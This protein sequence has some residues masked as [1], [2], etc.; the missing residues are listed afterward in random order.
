VLD[1]GVNYTLGM[2]LKGSTVS[3]TLN[4]QVVLGYAYNASTVDGRFGLMAVTG[5][6]QFDNVTVKTTD[7]AVA[8]SMEHMLAADSPNVSASV[9]TITTGDL[10]PII[11]E[12][13]RRLSLTLDAAQIAA[14]HTVTFQVTDLPWLEIGDYRDGTIWIDADAAGYGWFVDRTPGDDREFASQDGTLLA[15]SGLAA[16][17][18]DLLT[19]V[20]HELGHVVGLER[21][22][23]GVM[24]ASLTAGTRLAPAVDP[25]PGHGALVPVIDWQG[26]AFG[27]GIQGSAFGTGIQGTPLP[28]SESAGWMTDFA[29]HL[30]RSDSQ[31]NPNAK[32]KLP[33]PQAAAK[34]VHD[35]VRRIGALFG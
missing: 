25:L 28:G 18:M 6:T 24:Q 23:S 15:V 30:G 20:M 14:L 26:S 35:A 5:A 2:S 10:Q 12:A 3:V 17:H 34:V 19:V 27:T 1:A 7:P 11:D 9:A 16:G 31:R 4:G 8:L 21:T 22:E 13:I 29:N 32:I 33:V